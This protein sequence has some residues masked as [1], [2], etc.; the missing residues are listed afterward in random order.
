MKVVGLI[1]FW[2]GKNGSRDL[3][4]LA[5]KYLIE[6][7]VE[8]LNSSSFIDETIIYSSNEKV[9]E[10]LDPQL[11]VRHISRPLTLDHEDISLEQIIN[12]FMQNIEVD[13]IVVLHPYSPF[14]QEASVSECI[15]Q[16]MEGAYDSS[17]TA[18]ELQKFAWFHGKPL[19]FDKSFYSPKLKTIDPVVVEQGLFYVLS[20]KAFVD[21]KSRIGKKPY[22]QIINH[23]EG[24]EIN[25]TKDFEIAELIV[26]SGMFQGV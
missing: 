10:Y 15:K 18:L 14:L 23:F 6:Y 12:E 21:N 26:N 16:V 9:L 25:D 22:I 24:H 20:K 5:G 2:F 19:N 17:F 3:K 11:D 4:K 7:S 13:I 1:P 8:L